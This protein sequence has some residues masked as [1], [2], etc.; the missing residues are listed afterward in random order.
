MARLDRSPAG[1]LVAEVERR[2]EQIEQLADPVAREAATGAV[3]ALLDLYG[4]GLDRIVEEIA[5]RDDGEFAAALVA[6]D[7]VAHLLLLHGLHPVPLSQ[8]VRAALEEVRPYLESHG[9]DV[10]LLGVQAPAVHLRLQGSCRGCPSSTVT[11]KLAIENAI[12][13]AAPEIEEVIAVDAA[14]APQAQPLLQI[15]VLGGVRGDQAPSMPKLEA[16]WTV[17]G[18]LPD[19]R[20]GQAVL[21]TIG[22]QPILFLDLGTGPLAYR[23]DCPACGSPLTA[24]ALLGTELTCPECM[25]RYDPL[26]GGRC[27]DSPQLGLEAV[28]L[29]RTDDGLVKVALAVAA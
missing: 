3:G 14:P 18:S 26:R 29:L 4:A 6:D 15:E 24:A 8:R 16:Q 9:G 13:K 10:E 19:L 7:L 2:L 23:P 11:L 27:L 20:E 12:R 1:E 21:R 28:P 5:A 17:A 22:G 25:S